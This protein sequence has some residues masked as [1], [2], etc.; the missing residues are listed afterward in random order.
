MREWFEYHPL[1][2]FQVNK[3]QT[4]NPGHPPFALLL[5]P[6]GAEA[7]APEAIK[8]G[9]ALASEA[10]VA[11]KGTVIAGGASG[12]AFRD[13][14]KWARDL[15]GKAEDWVKMSSSSYSAGDN[16]KFSTHW[17]ENVVSGARTAYK[18]VIDI[19]PK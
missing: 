17:V 11:E 18:T 9:K 4:L 6:G 2:D 13:A 3:L 7:K 1:G 19:W 15:G 14:A 16:A 10:Q 12:T 8:L 5:V